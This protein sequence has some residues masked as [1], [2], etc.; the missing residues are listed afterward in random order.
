MNDEIFKKI[1]EGTVTLDDFNKLIS[2][3]TPESARDRLRRRPMAQRRT[4]KS[5]HDEE[6]HDD[7]GLPKIADRVQ[8]K[9]E[10]EDNTQMTGRG[11]LGHRHSARTQRRTMSKSLR[12]FDLSFDKAG[13]INGLREE[14]Q[15]RGYKDGNDY[16]IDT[17][18]GSVILKVSESVNI[19]PDLQDWLLTV[20]RARR[21][22]METPN[23][24]ESTQLTPRLKKAIQYIQENYGRPIRVDDIEDRVAVAAVARKMMGKPGINRDWLVDVLRVVE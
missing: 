5:H 10:R 22:G 21:I 17:D 13:Y 24:F 18:G 19:D 11:E 8:P 16:T 4:V 20:G 2:E 6:G 14:M 3:A 7:L 23:I 9:R 12:E 1:D 15:R